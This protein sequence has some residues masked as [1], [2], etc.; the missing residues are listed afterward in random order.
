[1]NLSY[2]DDAVVPATDLNHL[3]NTVLR[4]S[5]WDKNGNKVLIMITARRPDGW[6]EYGINVTNRDDQ[7]IIYIGAIQRSIHAPSEF[8]S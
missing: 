5:E 2:L 8:H 6:L 4:A 3:M 7:R 1:M